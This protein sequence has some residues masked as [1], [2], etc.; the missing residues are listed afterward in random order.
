MLSGITWQYRNLFDLASMPGGYVGEEGADREYVRVL[1]HL[2]DDEGVG[3]QIRDV[4]D[5]DV[6]QGNAVFL[7]DETNTPDD[8]FVSWVRTLPSMHHR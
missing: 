7:F 2:V 3:A 6:L 4:L 1:R 8:K 5:A